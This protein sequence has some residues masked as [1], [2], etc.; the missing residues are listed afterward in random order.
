MAAGTALLGVAGTSHAQVSFAVQPVG[1]WNG[2]S[3]QSYALAIAL[4]KA[5]GSSFSTLTAHDLRTMEMGLRT[6]IIDVAKNKKNINHDDLKSGLENYTRQEYTISRDRVRGVAALTDRVQAD[7]GVT[8]QVATPFFLDA[9]VK[10]VVL[11][12]VTKINGQGQWAGHIVALLGVEGP[13]N[14]SQKVLVVN[15]GDNKHEPDPRWTC[16]SHLPDQPS[17]YTAH[18]A[19]VPVSSIAFRDFG[20]EHLVWTVTKVPKP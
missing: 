10:K 2:S 17:K 16:E 13:P 3:C 8:S 19:W 4:A 1:Q 18:V 20:G 15:S 14:S 12:S 7:T 6:A 11:T 9:V 5:K